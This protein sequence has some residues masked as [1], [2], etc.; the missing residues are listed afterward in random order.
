[1]RK[2]KKFQ[3]ATTAIVALCLLLPSLPTRAE[4]APA[5]EIETSRGCGLSQRI[6]TIDCSSYS[7]VFAAVDAFCKEWQDME[8]YLSFRKDSGNAASSSEYYKINC[9][10]TL[11]PPGINIGSEGGFLRIDRALQCG[12]ASGWILTM[13]EKLCVRADSASICPAPKVD[14][15]ALGNP[16]LPATAEKYQSEVDFSDAG[17]HPLSFV[18][19]YRSS[20]SGVHAGLSQ[21][22]SN[23]FSNAYLAIK[24]DAAGNALLVEGDQTSTF[25]KN[26]TG[27]EYTGFDGQGTIS[28]TSSG[29]RVNRR[30]DDSLLQ[31]DADGKIQSVTQRNGWVMAY[32]YNAAGNLASVANAFNKSIQFAYNAAGQLTA[33]NTPDARTI[34]Y[35]YDSTGRLSMVDYPD[36]KSRTYLYENASF[37]Q[38]LTGIVDESGGRYATF[39]YDGQ[40]RAI[41]TE[42]AGPAGRYQVSYPSSGSA[43]VVDPLGTSRSYSYGTTKGKLAVV[44]GSLPSGD[45]E[46]DARS[47][48]Q[49]ANGLITS[50]TDFKG[51]VTTMTWDVSRRLP[52]SMTRA[53][54]Y[55]EAQTV[56]TQWHP[57][58]AL[59]VLVTESGHTTAWTYDA[60][61]NALFQTVTDTATGKTQTW[62][63]TYNAQ[64]LAATQTAP[65]GLTTSYTYDAQGNVTKVT[66]GLS[67]DTLYAYDSANRVVSTT[68]PINAVTTYSYDARDRLLTQNTGGIQTTLTYNPT[69][70]LATFTLSTGLVLSYTYDAAHRLTGWSNNRGESGS[71]TLDAMGNRTAEQIKNA[72][73]AVARAAVRSINNLNRLSSRTDG[74]NQTNTFGYDANGELTTDT[75]GLNQSTQYG[76]DGLRRVKSITNATSV[77]ATL[78]YNALDAVTQAKDFKGI[79]TTYARDAQGNATSEANPD[80]GT[81]TTDYDAAGLPSRIVDALGQAT[82]I[83]RDV[84]GRPTQLLFADGKT[85]T[86]RYDL[87]PTSIGYLSEIVDRSGTTAYTRDALGRVA[88]MRRTLASGLVQQVAYTYAASG[89]LTSITYPDASVLGYVYDTTGRLTQLTWNNQPLVTGI[90]WNPM[91]QPTAWTWAFVSPSL[92]PSLNASRS[93]DTAGRLTA[94]EFSSYVYDAA[95]RITSLTQQLMQPADTDPTHSTIA[96]ANQSWTVG[97]DAVGRITGFNAT[98]NTNSAGFSYDANGN[99][100]ASTRTLNSQTTSRSYTVGATSNRLAGFSQTLTGGGAGA[101]TSVSYAY[102]ANGDMTSDGLRTYSYDAEGRLSAVTT[103]ATDASPTTRYAH[104]ALGQRVFKTEP[105]YPPAA[106]DESDPGFLQS[107]IAFFTKFW[108]PGTTEAEKLGWAYTYDEDGTLIAEKGTGGAN[109]SGSTQYISLP[110]ASGPMPVAVVI[111][112]A[113]YA[114]HSDH[115]NTPRRLTDATGQPVWQWPY[116]AFGDEKPTLAKN[117]FANLEVTPNPGTTNISAVDFKLRFPG[118][119]EDKESGLYYN[120]RRSYSSGGGFYTQNDPLGLGGGWNRRTYVDANPLGFVDPQGLLKI[121]VFPGGCSDLN[122]P[123]PVGPDYPYPISTPPRP[124]SIWNPTISIPSAIMQ[125]CK[126]LT[127]WMFSGE[128]KSRNKPPPPLVDA[129]DRP[130]SIIEEPG[131]DGQ[132]TTHNGD[133]TS[134]QYRGSGQDHGGI[135]R[136]NVKE[137]GINISP[138]GRTFIDKGRVRPASPSEIPGG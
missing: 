97:Y 78:A 133:G 38:A 130:H 1:M 137:T 76:L 93:Y 34:G 121:C 62:Q 82:S 91:G 39:N 26:A 104:N 49:D 18:R 122:P 58:F 40:G 68:S 63:W 31:F 124:L 48:I 20:P 114:V 45:G 84:L 43:T 9:R 56:T 44:G 70:T 131:K 92:S 87:S 53:S 36:G 8:A 67:Q 4:S 27:D 90:A 69:G 127:D 52:T 30:S 72:S 14:G 85:T 11:Q 51:V 35:D 7:T 54:G 61:G 75:N 25:L 77:T 105:L 98:G 95:G 13:P 117:R 37:P 86:L 22:G 50:E 102:N 129:E 46:G 96:S 41:S 29:W 89:L 66:N 128:G 119:I 28:K 138:D 99:R 112:G 74:P 23:W 17:P 15:F 132:Y 118:Q 83:T 21:L 81:A 65:G 10:S 33:I 100:T 24:T 110:T 113:M 116:S 3:L 107:L 135:P 12:A 42:H 2:D 88:L 6:S 111:D 80:I 108:A 73:G 32:A 59:P 136:P 101:S 120:G 55:P 71:F 123:P 125:G 57:S 109:S 19:S 79:T 16:I 5:L 64:G 115:L 94:T 126:A 60:Q 103:G 106:G 134:K 47:R